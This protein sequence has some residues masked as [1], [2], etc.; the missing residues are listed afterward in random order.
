MN[1]TK[2]LLFLAFTAQIA[3]AARRWDNPMYKDEFN[4]AN[5]LAHPDELIGRSNSPSAP[6]QSIARIR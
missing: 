6:S 3:R 4:V 2:L 5:F 1:R